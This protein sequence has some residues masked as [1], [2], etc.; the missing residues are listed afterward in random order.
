M[1][2]NMRQTR[3]TQLSDSTP[4]RLN[5]KNMKGRTVWKTLNYFKEMT[6]QAS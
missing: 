6:E 1:N 4:T 3:A 2:S 5:N